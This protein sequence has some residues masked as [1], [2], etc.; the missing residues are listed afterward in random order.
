MD[1]SEVLGH[2]LKIEYE[3]DA[4]VN[5]AQAEADRRMTEAEKLNRTAYDERLH[6]ETEKLEK[7][8]QIAKDSIRQLYQEELEAYM[9]NISSVKAD[10]GRFSALL[11]RFVLGEER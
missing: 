9:E 3:A 7:E 6:A 5:D 10:A 4:L 2:L 1:N 11:D 8:F